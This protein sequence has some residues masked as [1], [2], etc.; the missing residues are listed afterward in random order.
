M[1]YIRKMRPEGSALGE[2]DWSEKV[3]YTEEEMDKM[4]EKAILKHA[5]D[6]VSEIRKERLKKNSFKTVISN[7]LQYA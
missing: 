2:T 1:P 5:D 3:Y 7:N 4:L 6:L